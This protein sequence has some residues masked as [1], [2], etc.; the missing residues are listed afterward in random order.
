MDKWLFWL[1]AL[2]LAILLVAASGRDAVVG[3][4]V[5][6]SNASNIVGQR[7]T[8]VE[9]T[10]ATVLE[11]EP[12]RIAVI[13]PTS[14][15]DLTWSQSLYDSL[16]Q[17]Q[18]EAGGEDVVEIAIT[19]NTFN[20]ADAAV[21]IRGYAANGFDLVIAHGS[22]YGPSIFDIAPDFPETS[23]AW[24]TAT[25]TGNSEGLDNIFAYEAR[26]EEGGFVNGVMA[27]KLSVSNVIGV[28][29]AVDTEGD[30][31][32]YIDGF[33]AG[34]HAIDPAITVN[35]IYTGSFGDT[36]LAAESAFTHIQLGADV[37]TGVGQQVVG[38]I[39]VAMSNDVF[40]LGTQS[41]QSPLALDIVMATQLY[42][43][44][45]VITDMILKHQAGQLGGTAYALTLENG[46]L[47]MIYQDNL[48]TMA[49][50]AGKNAEACIIAGADP[51]SGIMLPCPS[52]IYLPIIIR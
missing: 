1:L 51:L 26:A 14:K 38:A 21:A 27:A 25:D 17:L 44:K 28:V 46:G 23:F 37:L 35:I 50:T 12:I 40:W 4:T 7:I 42:N 6:K 22:Q 15:F 9:A 24:G 36:P 11:I 39:G 52:R 18:S 30:H 43:W 41:D 20:V 3:S 2:M 19:E 8:P 5:E 45:N 31:N 29:G 34:V 32:L 10:K 48:P 47:R 33:V 16:V 13:L 49:E